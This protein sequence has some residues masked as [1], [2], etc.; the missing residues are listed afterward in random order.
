MHLFHALTTLKFNSGNRKT[1]ENKV[2]YDSWAYRV[3]HGFRLVKLGYCGLFCKVEPIILNNRVQAALVICGLSAIL[4]I[5]DP[6]M[7]S[8]LEPILWF[9]VTLGLFIYK[10][11]IFEPIFGVPISCMQRGP[12]VVQYLELYNYLF[13]IK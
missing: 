6:E 12:P 4:C 5:C 9:T 7:A 13:N 3:Y 1:K 11:V 8:F 2:W 10:F